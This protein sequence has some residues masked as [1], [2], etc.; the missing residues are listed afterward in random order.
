M[1]DAATIAIDCW[2]S[3]VTIRAVDPTA[4]P[5]AIKAR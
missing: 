4:P 2:V 1:I 5:K 3:D